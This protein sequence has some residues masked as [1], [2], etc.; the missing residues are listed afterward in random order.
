MAAG[1]FG[2]W[3]HCFGW[4]RSLLLLST[5][6]LGKLNGFVASPASAGSS[7]VTGAGEVRADEV[8][9]TCEDG[10]WLSIGGMRR[11]ERMQ[12]S[13]GG[14]GG[15]Y[16]EPQ[17]LLTWRSCKTPVLGESHCESMSP[18]HLL[19]YSPANSAGG[20]SV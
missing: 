3:V 10:C 4:H 15:S 18:R 5:P 11:W 6:L 12:G 1:A 16:K 7:L 19:A 8:D 2:C 14:G 9:F 20:A 17:P 13:V